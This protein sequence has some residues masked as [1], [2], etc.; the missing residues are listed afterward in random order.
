MLKIDNLSNEID[1][2]AV[3]GGTGQ[4][5]LGL[6]GGVDLTNTGSGGLIGP[7]IV[8]ANTPVLVQ[9]NINVSDFVKNG[10]ALGT[11]NTVV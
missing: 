11:G 9:E 10:F 2:T 7:I 4:G 3:H 6:L 5:N 8:V 1:T